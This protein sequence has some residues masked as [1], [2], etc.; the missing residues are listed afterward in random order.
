MAD[1]GA[2]YLAGAREGGV[3]TTAKHFPGHGDTKTD[4]HVELPIVDADRDR[5]E[6]LELIPFRRAVAEGVDAVMTAHVA[7]PGILGPDGPPATLS[8]YFLT[9]LLREDMGFDGLLLTDAL[10]MRAISDGYGV[11]EAAVLAVEAGA[12]IILAPAD[13]W[14]T[15]DALEEAVLSGRISRERL[16][17]SVRRILENESPG[18][19]PPEP[20]GEPGPNRGGG[21]IGR[22]PG[23]GGFGGRPV[24]HASQ[25]PGRAD[26]GGSPAVLPGSSTW[27][28]PGART[29]PRAWPSARPSGVYFRDAHHPRV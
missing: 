8:P 28:M 27:C 21:G 16:D 11:G 9:E 20:D 18:G 25:G 14:V 17:A 15:V 26:S 19:A 2:A 4:S 22:T 10:R 23:L 13:V 3:L 6:A 5:L 7:V 12:D 24:H 1:L 29:S